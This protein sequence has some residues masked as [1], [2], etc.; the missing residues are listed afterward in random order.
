MEDY[1]PILTGASADLQRVLNAIGLAECD[2][3]TLCHSDTNVRLEITWS[4]IVSPAKN[5]KSVSHVNARNEAP[6]PSSAQ[7]P[8]YCAPA[9]VDNQHCDVSAVNYTH[10]SNT[11]LKPLVQPRQFVKKK[12]PSTLRRDRERLYQWKKRRRMQRNGIILTRI[13]PG[14]VVSPISPTTDTVCVIPDTEVALVEPQ[15]VIYTAVDSQD[16]A[17]SLPSLPE[18]LDVPDATVLYSSVTPSQADLDGNKLRALLPP[19]LSCVSCLTPG[20]EC[21]GGLK[22]CSKCQYVAYCSRS[23]QAANWKEHRRSC[24][25]IAAGLWLHN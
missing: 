13:L 4:K 10:I 8:T 23:C 2:G 19:M 15:E 5:V 1:P 20:D 3:W 14:P 24:K 7:E 17:S 21:E 18:V 25:D 22:K 12:S 9:N 6:M 16:C 11:N